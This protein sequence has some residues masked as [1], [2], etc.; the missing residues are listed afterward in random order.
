ML[1]LKNLL[2]LCKIYLEIK[3]YLCFFE[4]L[5]TISVILRIK[6]FGKLTLKCISACSYALIAHIISTFPWKHLLF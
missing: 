2:Y 5:D 6:Y 1:N 4:D 3:T